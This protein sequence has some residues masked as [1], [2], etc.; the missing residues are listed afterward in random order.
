MSFNLYGEGWG[1]DIDQLKEIIMGA[2]YMKAAMGF[3]D[4]DIEKLFACFDT[5]SNQLVDSLEIL[6]V[7]AL[8]SG[9]FISFIIEELFKFICR[10]GY[11]GQA[12]VLLW[13]I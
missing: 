11:C 4:G 7:L 12:A 5:D 1:L 13:F 9:R 3:S 6:M 8:S 10:N 2:T